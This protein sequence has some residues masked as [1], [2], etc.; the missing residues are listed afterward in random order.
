MLAQFACGIH[1]A[2]KGHDHIKQDQI[3]TISPV[4]GDQFVTVCEPVELQCQLMRPAPGRKTFR[5]YI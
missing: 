3:H 2:Q 1:A 4:C 5:K